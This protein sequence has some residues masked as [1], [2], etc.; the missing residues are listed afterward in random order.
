M[1]LMKEAVL[2]FEEKTIKPWFFKLPASTKN[3][4]KTNLSDIILDDISI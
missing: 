2:S 3:I 1:L 4:F